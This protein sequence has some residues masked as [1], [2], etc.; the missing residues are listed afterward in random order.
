MTYYFSASTKGFYSNQIHETMPNDVVEITDEEHQTL[1]DSQS[2]GFQIS[3]DS[4]GKPISIPVP[5]PTPEE[6]AAQKAQETARAS[7]LAKLTAL[8]L[9]EAEVRA[10]LG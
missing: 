5:P 9:T 1:L 10:L 7:A 8:G 4:N 2:N 3:S 6:I